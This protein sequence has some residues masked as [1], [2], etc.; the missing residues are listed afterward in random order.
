MGART[1]DL[2]DWKEDG[3]ALFVKGGEDIDLVFCT[4]SDTDCA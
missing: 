4:M 2:V 3:F 1:F